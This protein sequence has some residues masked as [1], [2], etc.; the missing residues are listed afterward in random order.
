MEEINT[1]GLELKRWAYVSVISFSKIYIC[2]LEVRFGYFLLGSCNP[3]FLQ[4]GEFSGYI[5]IT[6]CSKSEIFLET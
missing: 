1:S 2:D 5:H 3:N 4:S 6:N